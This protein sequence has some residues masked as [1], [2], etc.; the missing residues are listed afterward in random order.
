[1]HCPCEESNVL[2]SSDLVTFAEYRASK[3][4]HVVVEPLIVGLGVGEGFFMQ[5]TGDDVKKGSAFS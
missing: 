2:H 5:N 3:A 4:Q 1:M